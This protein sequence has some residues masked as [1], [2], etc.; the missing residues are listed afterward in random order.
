MCK[1]FVQLGIGRTSNITLIN[2]IYPKISNFSYYKY[3]QFYSDIKNQIEINYEKLKL[4]EKIHTQLNITENM[5]ISDERLIGW[6]PIDWERYADANLKM[7]GKD[8]TILIILRDPYEYI[9]SMYNR[10]CLVHGNLM[11]PNE[12]YALKKDYKSFKSKTFY[13]EGFSYF[14]IKEI[15]EKRF[16]EVIFLDYKYLKEMEFFAEY[17]KLSLSNKKELK[18]I[19][20]QKR[21]NKSYFFLTSKLTTGLYFLLKIFSLIFY[22]SYFQKKFKELKI[23]SV[24][25]KIKN[26]EL[27]DLVIRQ[28]KKMSQADV[29][30][31]FYSKII[32]LIKWQNLMNLIDKNFK[33][34]P[35]DIVKNLD[36][37]KKNVISNCKNEY[38]KILERSK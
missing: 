24:S 10:Q 25:N 27:L 21:E 8:S 22:F 36:N 9:N 29:E 26:K 31:N 18:S 5:I 7:F 19:Y 20:Q 32:N 37:E 35:N 15:Y 2:E 12:Y 23:K 17:F 4:G 11:T 28:I 3:F 13:L 38:I 33:T 34:N 14:K 1:K 30:H 6:N 16:N